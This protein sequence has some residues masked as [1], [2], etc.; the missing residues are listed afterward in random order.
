LFQCHRFLDLAPCP[1]AYCT[2]LIGQ[3]PLQPLIRNK[4][5][6]SPFNTLRPKSNVKSIRQNPSKSIYNWIP[7]MTK[8]NICLSQSV[9][10]YNLHRWQWSY[11]DIRNRC[12]LHWSKFSLGKSSFWSSPWRAAPLLVYLQGNTDISTH[13]WQTNQIIYPR[14][15]KKQLEVGQRQTAIMYNQLKNQMKL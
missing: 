7:L 9:Q 8:S 3:I 5:K 2:I 14:L 6:P 12:K 1:F 11:T 4:Y 15:W 10:I 13:H